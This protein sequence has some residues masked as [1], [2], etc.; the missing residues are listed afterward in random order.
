MSKGGMDERRRGEASV[1]SQ[2]L[3]ASVLQGSVHKGLLSMTTELLNSTTL[4]HQNK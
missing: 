3:P 1:S 4:Q 2:S